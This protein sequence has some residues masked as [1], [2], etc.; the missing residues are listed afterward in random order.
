MGAED[1]KKGSRSKT[2]CMNC[3]PPE[4]HPGCSAGCEK[5]KLDEEEAKKKKAFL[6]EYQKFSVYFKDA[7][8]RL[9]PASKKQR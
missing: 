7:K 1:M 8:E 9:Y 4:R 2:S 6:A 3:V 5:K